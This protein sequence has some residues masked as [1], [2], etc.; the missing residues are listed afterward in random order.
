MS[1]HTNNTDFKNKGRNY[2]P[3]YNQ[4]IYY[5][6]NHKFNTL[7]S[8]NQRSQ[9]RNIGYGFPPRPPTNGSTFDPKIYHQKVENIK[10]DLDDLYPI[11]TSNNQNKRESKDI[12]EEKKK[13][14]K[15]ISLLTQQMKSDCL[16]QSKIDSDEKKDDSKNLLEDQMEEIDRNNLA[17]PKVQPKV[18]PEDEIY[19]NP[20]IMKEI[21]TN[22]DKI[23][24]SNNQWQ[25]ED[26][27]SNNEEKVPEGIVV[28]VGPIP[29][30]YSSETTTEEETCFRDVGETS[31]VDDDVV[32]IDSSDFERVSKKPTPWNQ[33]QF[34]SNAFVDKPKINTIESFLEDSER[35]FAYQYRHILSERGKEHIAKAS[36]RNKEGLDKNAFLI[37]NNNKYSQ[38]RIENSSRQMIAAIENSSHE[39]TE[40]SSQGMVVNVEN[41]RESLIIPKMNVNVDAYLGT[42]EIL[43]KLCDW[44]AIEKV[45]VLFEEFCDEMIYRKASE[46]EGT[47]LDNNVYQADILINE[48]L[49]KLNQFWIEVKNIDQVSSAIIKDKDL[50][51]ILTTYNHASVKEFLY[52]LKAGVSNPDYLRDLKGYY[53]ESTI[54]NDNDIYKKYNMFNFLSEVSEFSKFQEFWMERK[55]ISE[56]L[57][58]MS[59]GIKMREDLDSYSK[60][61]FIEEFGEKDKKNYMMYLEDKSPTIWKSFSNFCQNKQQKTV[62]IK[63]LDKVFKKEVPET[64]ETNN[65]LQIE[66]QVQNTRLLENNIQGHASFRVQ[67]PN[68]NLLENNI[69]GNVSNGYEYP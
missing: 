44:F 32:E 25:G 23:H 46:I 33:R 1:T 17:Q 29:S 6:P 35:K 13:E 15:H 41:N 48:I 45:K 28:S 11:D 63:I 27:H 50:E 58:D 5:N 20:E 66:H 36:G 16:S 47:F 60:D 49:L 65:Q 30:E 40:N 56:K 31:L 43:H 8:I 64:P 19:Y 7:S 52:F 4:P 59:N 53:G 26:I 34:V 12:S 37:E 21:T 62:A 68:S 9:N 57:F 2:Q 14:D 67:A 61:Q 38:L 39:M 18:H 22:F 10:L 69:Q 3:Y 51:V 54:I 55:N 24:Y 42:F